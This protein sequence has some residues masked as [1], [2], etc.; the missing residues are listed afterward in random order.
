MKPMK[1]YLLATTPLAF[2][3][4]CAVG[5]D[6]EKPA[7]PEGAGYTA[8][9]I[10][11]TAGTDAQ[12]GAAQRFVDGMD[13]PGQWWT[14]FHSEPLNALIER[15]LKAN[16]DLEA[17]QAALRGAMENVAAERGA[18]FP[19]VQAGF[20]PQRQKDAA[21]IS[22][23]LSVP[24]S[25]FN[26]YTAQ[27]TVSYMPDLFGLTRRTVESA[28][29]QAEAQRYQLEATYLTITSNVVAAAITEA[30]LRAQIA[31]TEAIVEADRGALDLLRRQ[32][33]LGQVAPADVAAQQATLA[34]AQATLPGL[35]KQLAQQRDLIA[36]LAGGLPNQAPAERFELAGLSLPEDLPLSLPAKLIEQRPDIQSAEAQLHSASAEVGV[37]IANQLPNFTFNI[38]DGTSAT[39]IGQL[40]LPGNGFWTIGGTLS[41]TVL[42]G[43]TLLHRR[44][45]AD[46]A[47]EQAAAQ[48]RG[49]VIGA[50]QNVADTLH[51]LQSDAET[52]EADLVAEKAAGDSLAIARKQLQLGAVAYLTLLNAEQ[53]YQQAVLARVQAQGSRYADTVA[54]FQSLGGGW[55]NREDVEAHKEKI[56]LAP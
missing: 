49:A 17:A 15:S 11:A 18:F 1:K 54:L 45:Q 3:A 38:T 6:F 48:Y 7:V 55:W 22:P 56:A 27:V 8:E 35:R 20:T 31:A 10:A 28:E 26:L 16:P 21:Q 32:L 25:Y 41:Q 24:A 19:T 14:L 5:P 34:Q 50:F 12:G 47:L 43:G 2:L 4:G 29:A 51:A 40:F 37:A 36:A 33:T 44:R 30:S 13:I 9:P 39:Q 52:L 53:T 46:A 23:T 42:D